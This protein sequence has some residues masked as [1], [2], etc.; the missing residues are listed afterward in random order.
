MEHC[1]L[2]SPWVVMARFTDNVQVTSYLES[3]AKSFGLEATV[4]HDERYNAANEFMEVVY[5]LLEGSWEDDAVEANKASGVYTN[6]D[7]VHAINHAGCA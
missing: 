7:K 6:P 3:A 5:K 2:S 1:E 4:E